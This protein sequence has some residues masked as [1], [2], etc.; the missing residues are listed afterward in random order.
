VDRQLQGGLQQWPGW[1][2]P[3]AEELD[4]LE[5]GA[6]EGP[7]QGFPTWK[8][9][10]RARDSCRFTTGQI[11]V[12]T[13]R[14]HVH[15]P[16]LGVLKTHESTRKLARRLEQGT[17]RILA[18]TVTRTADRWF[19]SFDVE[20][21]RAIPTGNG[22]TSVVGVDVGIRHLAVLS[23]GAPPIPNPRALERSMRSLRR[24]GRELSRRK[25]GSARRDR[26]RRR[27]ARVHARTANVRREALHHLTTEL[28]NRYG[29]VV[30]EQL[31]M[32]GMMR[33]RSLARAL[34]DSG[35]AQLRCLLAYKTS[36][37][38][39]RLIVA[40]PFYPSSKTCSTCGWLKAKFTLQRAHLRVRRVR[41]RPGSR[42]KRCSESRQPSAAGRPE[43]LGDAKRS[44]SG[45]KTRVAGRTTMKREAGTGPSSDKTG[46][47]DA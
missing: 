28:A 25:P 14:K 11:K 46:S 18:A 5:K 1:A 33:N 22:K 7:P 16:R 13:D 37:Y 6:P 40:D 29:I 17:A 20:V 35:M 30:V 4:R 31:R 34:T 15:L 39:S 3:G 2:R 24:T 32:A 9:K 8:K 10:G 43:W 27:L 26:T 47:V 42:L 23:T 19:V 21:E 45:H 44:W 41:S 38:G 12:L 36:W